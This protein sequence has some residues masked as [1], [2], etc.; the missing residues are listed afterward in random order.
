MQG[1]SAG[2]LRHVMDVETST[3]ARDAVGEPIETWASV[4]HVRAACESL[5][6]KE[7]L[8]GAQVNAAADTKI[9][10]RYHPEIVPEARMR[11]GSRIFD[12]NH[13]NN[14]EN[15]NR[16]MVLTCQELR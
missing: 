10:V 14:I 16:W 9:T 2:M 4:A 12:I 1:F 7:L 6:G 11:W 15:R 3:V 8:I 13:V 5:S